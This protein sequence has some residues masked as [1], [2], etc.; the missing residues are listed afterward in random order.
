MEIQEKFV[1]IL[2]LERLTGEH[3]ACKML[4]F[5]EE[6]GIIPKQCSGQCYDGA[7]NC[8]QK[9]KGLLVLS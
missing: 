4:D 1:T 3:I 5:Y 9:R 2:D 7:P 6:S 8:N